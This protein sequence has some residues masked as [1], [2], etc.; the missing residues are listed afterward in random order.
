MRYLISI[1]LLIGLAL[2]VQAQQQ[3]PE[4]ESDGVRRISVAEAKEAVA[5]GKA[6][7]VDV[8]SKDSYNSG[9]IKGALWIRL[10]DIAARTRLLPRNK[11]I[12]TYCTCLAEQTSALAV[13]VLKEKGLDNAAALL[14]G[15]YAWGNAG[16]PTERSEKKVISNR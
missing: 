10:D 5:Q 3:Q 6:I 13:Q 1:V 11:L 7:I 12:I 2:S 8:R 16:F 4:E 9:H 15:Y 14:G